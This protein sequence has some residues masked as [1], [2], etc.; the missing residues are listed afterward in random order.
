M[1]DINKKQKQYLKEKESINRFMNKKNITWGL[2]IKVRSY[3]DY[4]YNQNKDRVT[5][6]EDK[7]LQTLSNSL[8]QD[9]V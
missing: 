6:E 2:R 4:I 5:E 9:I 1:G 3:I 7:T 8:R